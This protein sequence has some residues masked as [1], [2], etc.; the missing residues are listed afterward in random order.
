MIMNAGDTGAKIAEM[1]K[2]LNRIQ[3]DAQFK[4]IK[5]HEPVKDQFNWNP[6]QH[7]MKGCDEEARN[8]RENCITKE[9]IKQTL[10]M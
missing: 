6:L 2:I 9:R 4:L 8:I 7:L 5:G 1:K 10:N 3:F